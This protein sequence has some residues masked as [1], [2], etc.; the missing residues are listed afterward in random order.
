MKH[1]SNYWFNIKKNMIIEKLYICNIMYKQTGGKT[2]T[3][4]YV[5]TIEQ[6]ES[7]MFNAGIKYRTD[8]LTH[9]GYER[10]YDYFLTPFKN[11]NINFFEIGVD[12]GRSLKL[13]NDYFTKGKIYGMDIDHEYDHEKGKVF[14]GDQ[15]NIK[16]LNRIIKELGKSEIILDDGSHVPE[17]Q[18]FSFNHLFENLLTFGG[19][20]IIEDIETSYW[21]KS[22]LYGYNVNAGYDKSNNIVNIFRNISDIVNREFLSTDDLNKIKKYNQINFENLKYISFIMFGQN[23]IIIKKMSKDEFKKY[24]TRKYRFENNIS[25]N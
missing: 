15:S 13:W 19:I 7:L 20:Y 3:K 21:K 10:F 23:C 17:H 4:T 5:N 24:G 11:K 9:H 1:F 16:D 12:K 25:I 8:K 18:L 2:K 14:K 22:T 6:N